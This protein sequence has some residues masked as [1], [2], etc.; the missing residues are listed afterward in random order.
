MTA[1]LLVTSRT[2]V[3]SRIV[4]AVGA[5]VFVALACVGCGRGGQA[6]STSQG[7]GLARPDDRVVRDLK[8]LVASHLTECETIANMLGGSGSQI[9][10][11]SQKVACELALSRIPGLQTDARLWRVKLESDMISVRIDL[12][13]SS[14]DIAIKTLR[15]RAGA[16]RSVDDIYRQSEEAARKE[17]QAMTEV[18]A[19]IRKRVGTIRQCMDGL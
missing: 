14:H 7:Q 11:S 1:K 12:A 2:S 16:A 17:N 8:V 15:V 4:L 5:S 10:I 13:S 18:A 9:A 6:N 19:D 3:G